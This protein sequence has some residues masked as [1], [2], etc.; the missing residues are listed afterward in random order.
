MAIR[1]TFKDGVAVRSYRF[2]SYDA[3]LDGL[4]EAISDVEDL[5]AVISA[6]ATLAARLLLYHYDLGD[7]DLDRLLAY[8]IGDP[9]SLEWTRT[10][11]ETATGAGGKKA[12]AW[13]RLTLLARERCP[14]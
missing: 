8:R 7:G 14:M 2:F 4:V 13:R 3:A 12:G 11:F 10:V 6:V 9:A 1:P 5:D